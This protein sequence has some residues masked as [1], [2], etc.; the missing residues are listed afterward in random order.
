MAVGLMG[1]SSCQ[2][3][4]ETINTDFRHPTEKDLEMDGLKVGGFYTSFQQT[5]FPVG[6]SGTGYVNDYQ[7]PYTLAGACWI[8]YMSPSQNKWVGSG[9]PSYALKKWSDYTFTVMYKR[10]FS[11]WLNL[12]EQAKGDETVEALLNIIKVVGVHKATDSFGPIP[13]TSS[14]SK[15]VMQASYDS[16]ETVYRTMLKELDDAVTVLSKVNY[17]VLPKYDMIYGGNVKKW[18]KLANSMMLRLAMRTVYADEALAREYAEK[19]ISNPEGVITSMEEIAKLSQGAEIVLKNPMTII[20]GAYNDLRMGAE[21]YSYMVGYNDPRTDKYFVKAKNGGKENFY[22]VF[23][24]IDK[25]NSYLD[26]DKFSSLNVEDATP[27]YIMKAS[28]VAFLRA[29]GALR[30]WSMGGTAEDFYNKAIAL[31]F[32][33]NGLSEAAAKNYCQDDF[34]VPAKFVDAANSANNQDAVSNITIKWENGSFEESLERIITQKY[35]ALFPDGQEAW[36]EFRRTGYPHIFPA[37]F[38]RS[39]AEVSGITGPTRMVYS[40]KEYTDNLGNITKAV[41]MLGG[42]DLGCTRLWWDKKPN[43]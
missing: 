17:P 32:V 36:S 24:S 22:P 25:V 14:E 18:I 21:I 28:E 31:S 34:N 11:N 10:T 13:Y 41:E 39:D 38:V 8:G 12:K 2:T 37:R 5:I 23:K 42:Q 19:A 1:L 29:E 6:S 30:N 40:N 27:I 26:K 33:E 43:K 3:D 16:Q 20:N 9:Y 35:I 7:I 4:F 15:D